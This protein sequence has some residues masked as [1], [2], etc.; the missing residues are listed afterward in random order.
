MTLDTY[1]HVFQELVDDDSRPTMSALTAKSWR[2]EALRASS[3][4]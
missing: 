1:G 2:P 3:T 4:A